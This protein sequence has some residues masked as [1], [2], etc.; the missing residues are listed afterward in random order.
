[1]EHE[2]QNADDGDYDADYLHGDSEFL[3][4][5]I[6]QKQWCKDDVARGISVSCSPSQSHDQN[7]KTH[8]NCNA[9]LDSWELKEYFASCTL[10]LTLNDL[11]HDEGG[12]HAQVQEKDQKEEAAWEA[13]RA[14]DCN[15]WYEI[16]PSQSVG[17]ITDDVRDG[18]IAS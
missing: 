16:E 18:V 13:I 7:D 3:C 17:N 12:G 9:C 6:G 2:S 8:Y 5:L 4:P 10:M 15:E 14:S 11:K 1:M